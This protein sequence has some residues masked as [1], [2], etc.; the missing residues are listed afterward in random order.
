MASDGTLVCAEE[1]QYAEVPGPGREGKTFILPFSKKQYH[2]PKD[3]VLSYNLGV[4]IIQNGEDLG[5]LLATK[6]PKKWQ[7]FTN[8]QLL[9]HL[10]G[11]EGTCVYTTFDVPGYP[12]ECRILRL[13]HETAAEKCF[14]IHMNNY[15]DR[16][17]D[18]KQEDKAPT[19][20]KHR[21][22]LNVL[23]WRKKTPLEEDERERDPIMADHEEGGEPLCPG[24]WI[25]PAG[26]PKKAQINPENNPVPWRKEMGWDE[27]APSEMVKSCSIAPVPKVR[28]KGPQAAGKRRADDESGGALERVF[29][30]QKVIE[31]GPKGS[32]VLTEANDCV[33]ISKLASADDDDED[34]TLDD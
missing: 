20:K 14:P 27:L 5:T 2:V 22:R 4:N 31:T 32:Y 29:K 3:A 28:A 8:E 11:V 12:D 9:V 15:W 24:G 33:V 13:V 26:C 7:P 17:K 19:G 10:R 16:V 6:A 23:R 25:P 21:A 30:W 1:P 34:D 18:P